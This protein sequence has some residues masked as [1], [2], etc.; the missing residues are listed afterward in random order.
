MCKIIRVVRTKPPAGY[1][2]VGV[3]IYAEKSWWESLDNAERHMELVKFAVQ[4]NPKILLTGESAAAVY[5]I[6]RLDKYSNKVH[7]TDKTKYA[8]SADYVWHLDKWDKYTIINNKKLT[9]Y[10]VTLFMLSKTDSYLST[11]ISIEHCLFH[12]DLSKDELLE[13]CSANKGLTGINRFK[14]LVQIASVKSESALETI[15]LF[16]IRDAGFVPPLQQKTI[17]TAGKTYRVDM[18]W[19]IS[20]CLVIL[21][22]D[23]KLKYTDRNILYAEKQRQDRLER[24]GHK[25]IRASWNDILDGTLIELLEKYKIKHRRR[26]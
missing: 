13:F 4:R 3:Y 5:K 10:A 20:G 25:V 16:A 9:S 12:F 21:E 24:L 14:K 26:H 22:L 7:F 18:C 11:L 1:E 17:M 8:N 19:E 6:P 23:G 2:K 15:G